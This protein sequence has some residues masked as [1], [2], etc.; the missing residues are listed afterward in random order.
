MSTEV[1]LTASNF[2]A[3]VMQSSLP[4]LIDFWAE[5]CMPCKMIAPLVDQIATQYAG[6]LKVGKVN[7]DEESELA[8]RF[9]IV[10]I[11]TL[12]VI[13]NGSVVRQRVGALPKHELENL[14]KDL[15]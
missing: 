10:S 5:W 7:V 14:F 15:I 4:V 9:G 3:E 6:K 13:K 2:D 8:N 12:L 11:P 1:K